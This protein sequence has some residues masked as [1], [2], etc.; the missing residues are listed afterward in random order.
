MGALVGNL[1]S[2]YNSF[3]VNQL[4]DDDTVASLELI[5]L[6]VKEGVKWVLFSIPFGTNVVNFYGYGDCMSLNT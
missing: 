6:S 5:F 1:G 3:A 4:N 2:R